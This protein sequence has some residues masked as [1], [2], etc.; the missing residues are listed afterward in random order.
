MKNL[1]TNNEKVFLLGRLCVFN[2]PKVCD[3]FQLKK[4]KI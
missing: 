4:R 3:N 2:Q 1:H